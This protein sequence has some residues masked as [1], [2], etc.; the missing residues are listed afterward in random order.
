MSE[1]QYYIALNGEKVGPF[2]EKEIKD[3]K[4]KNDTLVWCTGMSNWEKLKNFDELVTNNDYEVPPIPQ[5]NPN[6][7][8]KHLKITLIIFAICAL[9]SAV[10]IIVNK[11]T[12]RKRVERIIEQR[13]FEDKNREQEEKNQTKE[14]NNLRIQIENEKRKEEE[15]TRQATE[16]NRLKAIEL[17]KLLDKHAW[18]ENKLLECDARLEQANKFVL[19]RT[20][21]EK[22]AEIRQI[23][24]IKDA[25]MNQLFSVRAEINKLGGTVKAM[26]Y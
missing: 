22:N 11:C 20:R 7:K 2:T 10:Y 1:K 16:E 18:L 26:P 4:L 17:E 5:A 23:N 19:T 24:E 6:R 9:I 14:F 3:K 25:Y 13:A 12:E 21:S 8:K 15:K